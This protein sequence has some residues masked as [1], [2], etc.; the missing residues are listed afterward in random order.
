MSEMRRGWA[1]AAVVAAA[2][3]LVGGCGGSSDKVDA[4]P[5]KAPAMAESVADPVTESAEETEFAYPP[6]PEG[7]IDEKSDTEGWE[8]DGLYSS[9][10]E[11][12]QDICESLP[13]QSKDG[14]AAQWLAESNNMEGDGEK[15]LKFGVPKLCPKWAKTVKAAASGDYERWILSGEYE[16]KTNPK[17]Y[18]PDAELDVQ[19]IKPGT[20]VASGRIEDC[21]WERTAANGDIIANQFVT[22]ATRLTVTLQAGELFK[23]ECGPFKPVG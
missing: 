18:D 13:D 20:Y 7:E 2:V 16:V 15:I 19:E 23:N 9:A 12:V 10:S 3:L 8:Y 21:Y 1:V 4:K 14:S 17:P 11:Y 6:G 5:S 22:Q